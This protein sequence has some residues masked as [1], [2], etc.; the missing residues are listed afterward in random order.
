MRRFISGGAKAFQI[1][2]NKHFSIL[3][4]SQI[5]LTEFFKPRIPA[6]RIYL[7]EAFG[8]YD[9]WYTW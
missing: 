3:Q 2:P 7:K 5:D 8:K 6:I 4:S 9:Q 1:G